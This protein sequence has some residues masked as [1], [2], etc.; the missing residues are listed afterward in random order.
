VVIDV[1]IN[2]KKDTI[3]ML[4]EKQYMKVKNILKQRKDNIVIE[5]EEEK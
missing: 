5:K 2:N 3:N 4:I 1:K